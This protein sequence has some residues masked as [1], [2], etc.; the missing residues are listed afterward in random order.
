MCRVRGEVQQGLYA[1]PV[2]QSRPSRACSGQHVGVTRDRWAFPVRCAHHPLDRDMPTLC[3]YPAVSTVYHRWSTA[4]SR[5][6]PMSATATTPSPLSQVQ[7]AHHLPPARCAGNT[8]TDRDRVAGRK[9]MT[10]PIV[11]SAG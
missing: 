6:P 9:D 8:T 1:F 7:W 2:S 3:L 4:T 10:L 11:G 5:K